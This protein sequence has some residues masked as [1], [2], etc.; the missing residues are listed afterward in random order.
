MSKASLRR[1]AQFAAIGLSGVLVAACGGSPAPAPD[2]SRFDPAVFPSST[3]SGLKGSLTWYDSSGGA[4]TE[5]K[6]STVWKD[7]T[8]L[9]G[10]PAQAEYTDGTSTKFRA[11]AE[12]GQ[13]PWNLI[14]FGSGGEFFQAADAGLLAPID[15]S[16]V[17]TDKLASTSVED[18]GIR[19]EENGALLA[20]NT[21]ALGGKTP[22]S[23]A[24]LF[25]TKDFPG[26]RCMYKYPVS[27]G[28]LEVALLAD[29]VPADK[30]YPLDVKR[31]IAKL[32]TIKDDIVW[33]DSGTTSL[34]LLSNGECSMGM[35]WNGRLFDAIENQKLPF[36]YTWNGGLRTA[37]YYAVPKGAPDTKTG[38]A[39]M[40]MWVL[41]R[42]GQIDFVNKTTY[43]TDIK[44]L[45]LD[46][47]QANV[48]PYIAQG[49]NVAKTVTEDS[50]Y[51]SKNL[52][53][54]SQE[55]AEFQS[56]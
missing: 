18:Y 29:G 46:D 49:P 4:T 40:A 37:A 25:N 35:L 10:L 3:F 17:P 32:A 14:E 38:M 41:D 50:Q 11:A 34:Q 2:A 42:Q 22:T 53:A 45:T 30:M 7:F 19:V 55:L 9:T 48:R 31:A 15:K 21:N 5:A 8:A 39:A 51:Y 47:Y 20:W 23:T 54:V 26:K 27:A 33:W 28:T 24:D 6:E 43:N 13:V 52:D 44:D 1:A 56:Q 12:A 16:L 36:G